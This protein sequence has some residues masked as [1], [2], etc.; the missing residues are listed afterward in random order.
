MKYKRVSKM[1]WDFSVIG[2][3]CWGAS[4]KGSWDGHDDEGQIKAIQKAIELGINFFDVAPIYGCGHAEEV[5]GKAVKGKRDK[6]F[7]ATKAGIPWNE[8][9][10][11]YN[12]VT[13]ENLLKEI[14][15]SLERLQ[16]TYVDL[17]QV[18]WPTDKD[19]PLSETIEA[20]KI[21]KASGKAK[22]IGLSNFSLEDLKTIDK[23]VGI[24]S[25]QGLY[26][27][28]EANA[29][30]YHNIPLQYRV[31]DEIFPEV[32]KE[33]MAFLPYSPLMQGLLTGKITDQTVFGENDVRNHNPKLHGD[34]R[35]KHLQVI[36]QIKEMPELSDKP[37]AEIAINY[38]VAKEEVT[39]IIATHANVEEVVMNVEAL[40]WVMT[41]ETVDRIDVLVKTSLVVESNL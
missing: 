39:S 20:L 33:G 19:V 13:K 16:M 10:E 18:H 32:K 2:F 8:N 36:E 9:Y 1:D 15:D 25:Y 29:S 5:L 17:L 4:G 24:V 21:I 34:M 40:N 23:E 12:D 31:A 35:M 3:G 30:S 26:N 11:G 28:L 37:L 38:L 6:V 22:Y 41:K 14:D 7:I 27:M